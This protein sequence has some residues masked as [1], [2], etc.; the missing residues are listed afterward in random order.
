MAGPDPR[1]LILGLNY[2]PEEIGIG[3]F[4]TGMARGLAARGLGV[5]VI[6]GKAYYPQWRVWPGQGRGWSIA[7]EHGVRVTRCPLYVPVQPS[8][9]KRIVHLFSFAFSALGPA[10]A[11]ALSRGRPQV[12]ICVAPALLSVPVAWLCARLA[13]AKLWIHIQDFEVEAAFAT[14][15]VD[16]GG[17]AARLARGLENGLLRLGDRVSTI[18]PQMCAKLVE[19]GVASARVAEVRNWANAPAPD[20]ACGAS[21]RAEWNLGQRKVALYS[22]NIANKQGIG[23][24]VEAAR[25]LAGRDDLHFVVCGEGPNRALLMEQAAGLSNISF[26]DLQPAGRVGE[27][28]AL[29]SVHLLPQIAG[30]ADLVLPS[31]LA[32][33]LFSGRPVVATALPG[34]GLYGE[35]D[36]CGINTPPG[37]APAFAAAIAALLDDQARAEALGQAAR[38]RGLDRWSQDAVIDRLAGLLRGA[39]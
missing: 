17:W 9:L 2:A 1:V 32:N 39:A 7:E 35:V 34:T 5:E 6:A 3:A 38:R 11:R 24:V 19:K 20:P 12:V 23:I 31:K 27:L 33:M 29:A 10:V 25:L 15:L 8:G 22:G 36:G 30:A 21:Y 28:L 16:S 26:H 4:T 13:G 18:S 14:G 37:D